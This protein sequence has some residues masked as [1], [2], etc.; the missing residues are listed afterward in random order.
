MKKILLVLVLSGLASF[1]ARAGNPPTVGQITYL[2]LPQDGTVTASNGISSSTNTTAQCGNYTT[3]GYGRSAIFMFPFPKAPF[4]CEITDATTTLNLNQLVSS[5]T[6]NAELDGIGCQSSDLLNGS[7]YSSASTAVLSNAFTPSSS[8][9]AHTFDVGSDVLNVAEANLNDGVGDYYYLRVKPDTT[10]ADLNNG[11]LINS[12]DGGTSI[13][14]LTFSTQTLPQ[15]GRVLIEYWNNVTGGTPASLITNDA[16]YPDKP[17]YREYSTVMEIPQN[18]VSVPFTAAAYP[19]ASGVA[20]TNCGSRMQWIFYPT[21]S[22]YRFA[23]AGDD[24]AGLYMNQTGTSPSGASL[25]CQTHAPTGYRDFTQATS[26]VIT[27]TPGQAYYMYAIQ[28]QG[29]GASNLSIGWNGGGTGAPNALMP[30]AAC[31][32]Y[33]PAVAYTSASHLLTGSSPDLAQAH[34]RLMLSPASVNRL[35]LAANNSANTKLYNAYQ[36]VKNYANLCITNG[37]S[38][39][40]G[41]QGA[42]SDLVPPAGG[43]TDLI[44]FSRD[45]QKRISALGLCYLL[46]N[47]PTFQ[48]SCVS[49]AYTLMQYGSTV[50]S[51][52]WDHY[53]FL[54]LPEMLNAYAIGYDWLSAGTASG[55][56]GFTTTQQKQ[57]AAWME[58]CGFSVAV[59]DY[60]TD[61]AR[62]ANAEWVNTN[63]NWTIICYSGL[64]FSALAVLDDP[65][66]A[67]HAPTI[68]D[69]VLQNLDT[70]TAMQLFASDGGCPEADC[71]WLFEDRYL[72]SLFACLETAAATDYKF[73]TMP[74]MA[75]FGSMSSYLVAPD[76]LIFNYGDENG[77]AVYTGG[78]GC[79][80]SQFYLGTKYNEPYYGYEEYQVLGSHTPD[81]LDLVWYD[82]TVTAAAPS[83]Y[84][85]YSTR[86][87]NAGLAVLQNSWTDANQLYVGVKGGLMTTDHT[88]MQ[89][90]GFVFDALGVRLADLWGRDSYGLVNYFNTKVT[91]TP[92]RFQ[93]YRCRAEGGNTLVFNPSVDG[94]QYTGADVPLINFSL[95]KVILDLT[96]AYANSNSIN[97]SPAYVSSVHRGFRLFPVTSGTAPRGALQVQDEITPQSGKTI[98]TLYWFMNTHSTLY[99]GSGSSVILQSK[100]NTGV[101][102]RCTIES[103]AGATFVTPLLDSTPLTTSPIGPASGQ[104]HGTDWTSELQAGQTGTDARLAIKLTG[105]S[106]ATT[107]TVDLVPYKSTDA[108][109]TGTLSS[110]TQ[111]LASW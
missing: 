58:S 22:T 100:D 93:Y 104:D 38:G 6:Y 72:A 84:I 31:A 68:M 86:Y 87:D 21:Q 50:G 2:D 49:T 39:S 88:N 28:V 73:D 70:T 59:T 79:G 60:A 7:D 23:V 57:I 30:A 40:S 95:S 94:G 77:D 43:N 74:G 69:D 83:G 78:Q 101:L 5:P 12:W 67:P 111:P 34:P 65:T 107:V 24:Y 99:S 35:Y 108:T 8:L 47:N 75:P 106:A 15:T 81:P 63:N 45:L 14:S 27:V 97:P 17:N 62:G 51:G 44:S 13:P 85:P 76:S 56:P 16:N 98:G 9:G 102:M 48:T 53:Q 32:P 110:P 61:L 46:S 41:G 89:L 92:N 66:D 64:A 10:P 55:A 36:S 82:T 80:P 29:S 109:P 54:D 33:D 91:D 90:G 4:G 1:A 103:P 37:T 19:G 42:L 3:G 26:E 96:S 25:I 20:Q 11:Y 18:N 71:Y 105:L 52:K